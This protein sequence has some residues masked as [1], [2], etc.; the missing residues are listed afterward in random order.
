MCSG[1]KISN[2]Q[3]DHINGQKQKA[4]IKSAEIIKIP[5]KPAKIS[6]PGIF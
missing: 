4:I 2:L 6:K 5:A 3:D 1:F